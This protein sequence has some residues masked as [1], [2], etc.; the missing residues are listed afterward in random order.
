MKTIIFALPLVFVVSG[1]TMLSPKFPDVPTELTVQC[2]PLLEAQASAEPSKSLLNTITK[3]YSA[4]A[5]CASKV[6]GWQEWYSKQKTIF[7]GK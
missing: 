3:N 2:S 6:S 1:C 5:E 4:Y 7:K